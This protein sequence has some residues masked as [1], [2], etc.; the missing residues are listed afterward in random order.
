MVVRWYQTY[1]LDLDQILSFMASP[2]QSARPAWFDAIACAS[3]LEKRFLYE[4]IFRDESYF[5]E[6]VSVS[7]KDEDQPV[8]IVDVGANVG[9]FSICCLERTQG[10][11]GRI[12]AIEPIKQTFDLL[13]S[14]L[15]SYTLHG[16]S[17]SAAPSI[18]PLQLGLTEKRGSSHDEFY[19]FPHAL[20][21]SGRTQC[22]SSG[23]T[24][25]NDLRQFID[26]ALLEHSQSLAIPSALKHA[27]LFLKRRA[28]WIY[29]LIVWIATR[30]LMLGATKEMCPTATLSS[31]LDRHMRL[32]RGERIHL[33]KIDVE[34]GELMVLKGIE[35]RHWRLIDQI[36]L[37]CHVSNVDAVLRVLE[38]SSHLKNV[39]V[40]QTEDLQGTSL[41][42][43]YCTI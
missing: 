6:G 42:M 30:V 35:K 29:L 15:D 39:T 25:S 26:N 37:E 28:P 43:I 41:W 36:V 31:V 10:Y 23:D 16:G 7:P 40:K 5:Q 20:G 11:R 13:R 22:M 17:C 2:S 38:A 1:D 3:G 33:V 12:L 14:N 32:D 27:A 21:W 34:G 24:M 19:V 8:N 9:L 4:E 18:T